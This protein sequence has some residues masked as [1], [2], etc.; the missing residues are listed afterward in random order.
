MLK[1]IASEREL[2]QEKGNV[3]KAVAEKDKV[4]AVQEVKE[5]HKVRIEKMDQAD[6][7]KVNELEDDPEALV[8]FIMRSSA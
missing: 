5:K 3:R 1:K 6:K 2:V 8:D 7:E 4:V